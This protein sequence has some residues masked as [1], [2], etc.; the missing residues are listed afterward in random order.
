MAT[1]ETHR[2]DSITP[3]YHESSDII[4]VA[5]EKGLIVIADAPQATLRLMLTWEEWATIR[6]KVLTF[7]QDQNTKEGATNAQ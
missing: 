6:R 5:N 1:F 3:D 2:K 7:L 4:S